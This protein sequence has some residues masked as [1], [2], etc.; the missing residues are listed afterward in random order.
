[1]MNVRILSSLNKVFLYL[2]QIL[3]VIFPPNP[4]IQRS[5]NIYIESLGLLGIFLFL[6]NINL[7]KDLY[8]AGEVIFVFAFILAWKQL[9]I[10]IHLPIFWLMIMWIVAVIA[11]TVSGLIRFP[12]V[13][14]LEQLDEA[15][16]M[17]R[18]FT[19]VAIGWWIGASITSIRNALIIVLAGFLLSAMPWILDWTTLGPMLEGVRP[20]RDILG[21]WSIHYATWAGLLLLAIIIQGKSIL[22]DFLKYPKT[23]YLGYFLLIFS[24][25]CFALGIYVALSRMVWIAVCVSLVFSAVLFISISF[26]KN[27]FSFRDVVPFAVVFLAFFVFGVSQFEMIS[28]RFLQESSTITQIVEGQW[29][30]IERTSLGQRVLLYR[31]AVNQDGFVTVFGWGPLATETISEHEELRKIY[32]WPPKQHHP[33]LHN[34]FLEILFRAGLFGVIVML[35]ILLCFIHQVTAGYRRGVI[36]QT[37]FVF[38]ITGMFYLVLTGMLNFSLRI[39]SL[40]PTFG[41]LMFASVL[42]LL[43]QDAPFVPMNKLSKGG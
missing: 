11:S 27:R 39:D 13:D 29:D 2:H 41:G 35:L 16:R 31:W 1:M 22:P 25:G 21:F 24:A 36:P 18:Y 12:F 10:L 4:A 20:G 38:F 32:N 15:R 34:D 19:L 7:S 28:K 26:A 23:S 40:L 37:L 30:Q 8:G 33:H 43:N 42:R 9:R 14:S 3:N 6:F 17:L 5:D